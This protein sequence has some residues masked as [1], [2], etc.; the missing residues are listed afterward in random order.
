MLKR[1]ISEHVRQ[2]RSGFRPALDER[3]CK[4][5]RRL[6]PMDARRS[7]SSCRSVLGRAISHPRRFAAVPR[8]NFGWENASCAR[9]NPENNRATRSARTN[10]RTARRT[11]RPQRPIRAEPRRRPFARHPL[12]ADPRSAGKACNHQ[13]RSFGAWKLVQFADAAPVPTPT[14]EKS[15]WGPTSFLARRGPGFSRRGPRRAG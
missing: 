7:P 1:R 12:L 5:A 3:R 4:A 6:R 8:R 10:R 15:P 2:N 13:V 11:R 9:D 14:N